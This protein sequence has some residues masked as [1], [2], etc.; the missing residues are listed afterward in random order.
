MKKDKSVAPAASAAVI[1]EVVG[2]EETAAATQEGS[3]E[4]AGMDASTTVNDPATK[5][6]GIDGPIASDV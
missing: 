4:T 2:G 1:D 3:K 5:Q 6:E